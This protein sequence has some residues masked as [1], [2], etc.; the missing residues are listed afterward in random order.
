MVIVLPMIIFSIVRTILADKSSD[1]AAWKKI[2]ARWVLCFV[3]LFF[4]EYVLATIDT[5]C[6]TFMDILWK[7]RIRLENIKGYRPF[8]MTVEQAIMKSLRDTGGITSLAYAI[9]FCIITILQIIFIIKYFIRFCTLIILFIIAPIVILIHS[10]NL[11]LGKNSNILGDFFRTYIVFS[12]MQPLHALFY[13]VF[14]FSL[15][16][17]AVSVPILGMI[18]LYALYR[19]GNIAK[20]MFGWEMSSSILAR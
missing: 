6:S 18:L 17:I 19:A 8:E 16:E 5:T 12:F 11:M 2:L 1:L 9:E 20:A 15:S 14:F 7:V 3:L 13:L 10:F 4:F